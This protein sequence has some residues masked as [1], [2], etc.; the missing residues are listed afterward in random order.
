MASFI[1]KLKPGPIVPIRYSHADYVAEAIALLL[2]LFSFLTLYLNWSSLSD[3]ASILSNAADE[4]VRMYS[5][6]DLLIFQFIIAMIYLVLTVIS[7]LPPR[8]HRYFCKITAENAA[9]QYSIMIS[10]YIW[11]KALLMLGTSFSTWGTVQVFLGRAKGVAASVELVF[12]GLF[13][14]IFITI[15]VIH[16]VKA[17]RAR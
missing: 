1:K 10:F 15:L 11:F 2:L 12:T 3:P 13:I 6:N 9:R 7:R 14:A 8:W 17:N 16:L 4:P 5:R